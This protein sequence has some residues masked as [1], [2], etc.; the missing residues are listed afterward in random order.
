MVRLVS[1]RA[2]E[3][4]RVT[5]GAYIPLLPAGTSTAPQAEAFFKNGTSVSVPLDVKILQ[6]TPEIKWIFYEDY[7][8]PETWILVDHY[9]L[10]YQVCKVCT[11]KDD[12][13]LKV[14]KNQVYVSKSM[15]ILFFLVLNAFV[16]LLPHCCVYT[17]LQCGSQRCV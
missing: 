6:T 10:N 15:T 1:V 5:V 13:M 7:L 12:V 11:G 3:K 4:I 2:I 17:F 14:V 16:N 8:S 9:V